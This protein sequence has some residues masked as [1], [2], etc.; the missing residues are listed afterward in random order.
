MT[1]SPSDNLKDQAARDHA[2]GQFELLKE[3]GQNKSQELHN[4]NPS[5]FARLTPEQRRELFSKSRHNQ[6]RSYKKIKPVAKQ[7]RSRPYIL[8]RTWNY[9]P[10]VFRNQIVGVLTSMAVLGA[11]I[12]LMTIW[13]II[14]AQAFA[15]SVLP[16]SVSTWP[17]CRRLTPTA[18]GCTYR[19]TSDLVWDD[20]AS[21]LKIDVRVLQSTNKHLQNHAILRAN[22]NL[23]IWRNLLALEN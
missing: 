21:L 17:E 15:P 7:L 23:I 12:S 19:I 22:S 1:I 13:P 11:G 8:R 4:I 20:A 14:E 9:L 3:L 5:L 2:E 18:D 10:N 6:S 16:M